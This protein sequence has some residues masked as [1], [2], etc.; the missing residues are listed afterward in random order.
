MRGRGSAPRVRARRFPAEASRRE[1]T[2]RVPFEFRSVTVVHCTA[3]H[4]HAS[5]KVTCKSSCVILSDL[6]AVSGPFR[7][8]ETRDVRRLEVRHSQK[9]HSESS[10]V[11]WRGAAVEPGIVSFRQL[12]GASAV[13][14]CP[15]RQHGASSPQ[16]VTRQTAH[17]GSSYF[18]Q[19]SDFGVSI[20]SFSVG[21]S[22]VECGAVHVKFGAVLARPISMQPA[23]DLRAAE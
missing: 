17:E 12:V 7:E 2:S 3:Y 21:Q 11:R 14:H 1:R 5:T 16:G 19:R 20:T 23:S 4:R 13:T 22:A 10:C 8:R 18:A 9:A 6:T 15:F